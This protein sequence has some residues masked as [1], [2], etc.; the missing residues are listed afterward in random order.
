MVDLNTID[1]HRPDSYQRRGF[2]WAECDF[3]R[4]NAPIFH[5]E[6]DDIEPFWAVTKHADI[7]TV[8]DNPGIFINGGPRLRMALKGKPEIGRA[9]L[10][11]F[12]Q[13]RNWDPNEPPDMVF[14]DNPR[15]RHM[16]K[17]SSWAFTQGAMRKM[18]GRFDELASDF[19]EK[20]VTKLKNATSAGDSADLVS[21]L[22]CKL[23]L[24]A[25]GEIMGLA[26]EDWPQIMMWSD[27][28][29]GQIS[30][31]FRRPNES[32]GSAAYRSMYD[33]RCYLESLVHESRNFGEHR[34]GFIDQ[35]VHRKVHGE[36][37]TDQ[38]LIGYLFL[39]IA[40]G[41]D[42]TRNAFTAGI[43]AFIDNPEQIALL[44]NNSDLITDAVEE[45]L[46]W[47]SPVGHFLRTTTE[48][49][50]LSNVK[51]KAGDTVALF[52]PSANRDEDVF[53]TPY[54]FDITRRPND[55]LA[56]G[57]GAHFCL[58]TNL[59]RAE[60][61]AS[62]KAILPYLSHLVCAGEPTYYNEPHVVGFSCLP[63][64]FSG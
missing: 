63:V 25:I 48:D 56:F 1:L 22:A 15:H 27:A 8:S 55:H 37:L 59:A 54:K 52:Y 47:A 28:L 13:E 6:R 17:H 10:D 18:Q 14:M 50:E 29:V 4:D 61:K 64:R 5:Y 53:P 9:G 38:Q 7:M 43:R 19:T 21:E 39:L 35:L 32:R 34:G 20:F 24:A 41:N 58:G 42:T 36:L 49:F 26:R 62:L 31:Q 51:I 57:F 44:T 2:P 23:P 30:P 40:A 3:L 46:R 11:S 12:G 33:F 60:L 16:R 45:M